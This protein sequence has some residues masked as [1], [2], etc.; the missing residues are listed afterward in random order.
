MVAATGALT[1]ADIRRL[2]RAACA[3]RF[4]ESRPGLESRLDT[5]GT[6]AVAKTVI[7]VERLGLTA[8]TQAAHSHDRMG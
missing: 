5:E 8:I 2:L 6:Y 3:H 7:T 1:G 4:G